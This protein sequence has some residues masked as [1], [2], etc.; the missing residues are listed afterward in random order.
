MQWLLTSG[1]QRKKARWVLSGAD[2]QTQEI[3]WL[4]DMHK[5]KTSQNV[6][7]KCLDSQLLVPELTSPLIRGLKGLKIC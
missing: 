2:I 3:I 6:N 7:G 1:N 5:V 4:S